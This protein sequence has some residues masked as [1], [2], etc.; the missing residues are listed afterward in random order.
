MSATKIFLFGEN[1]EY[2]SNYDHSM[3]L[4]SIWI[5]YNFKPSNIV[6]K[7]AFDFQNYFNSG[8]KR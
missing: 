7:V 2:I 6:H 4:G 3:P 5:E 1:T 8:I